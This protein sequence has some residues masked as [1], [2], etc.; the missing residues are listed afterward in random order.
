MLFLFVVGV[1]GVNVLMPGIGTMAGSL[2]CRIL[3]GRSIPT[4]L[5]K[6]KCIIK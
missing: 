1:G 5:H 2:D 3:P 6:F 4:Y